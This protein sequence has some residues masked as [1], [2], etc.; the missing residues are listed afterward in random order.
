MRERVEETCEAS[1]EEVE[2]IGD[3]ISVESD[4]V[5]EYGREK[6]EGDATSVGGV[7]DVGGGDT[8]TGFGDET[9]EASNATRKEEIMLWISGLSGER[10]VEGTEYTEGERDRWPDIRS[11]GVWGESGVVDVG[12]RLCVGERVIADVSGIEVKDPRLWD[13]R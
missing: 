6:H 1:M 10:G 7:N 12:V 3:L 5:E 2:N 4:V 9:S 13:P 11:T 8:T